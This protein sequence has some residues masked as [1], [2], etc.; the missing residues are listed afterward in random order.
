MNLHVC[1]G[2]VGTFN[3]SLTISSMSKASEMEDG[4]HQQWDESIWQ[5]SLVKT[6]AGQ[7]CRTHTNSQSL[8]GENVYIE[9]VYLMVKK[10][11]PDVYVLPSGYLT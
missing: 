4:D 10:S 7:N 2:D 9:A 6:L 11:V 8:D 5:K 1:R 3:G